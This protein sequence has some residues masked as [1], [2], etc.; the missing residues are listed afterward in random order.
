[1]GQFEF[2]G[3]PVGNPDVAE[4]VDDAAENVDAFILHK[5]L[6]LL[7]NRTEI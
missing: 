2:F 4:I 7:S 3:E 6:F 1:M 5:L